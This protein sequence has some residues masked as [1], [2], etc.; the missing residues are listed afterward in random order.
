MFVLLFIA[1]TAQAIPS[2]S[3]HWTFTFRSGW[4]QACFEALSDLMRQGNY[5]VDEI[6]LRNLCDCSSGI[7]QERYSEQQVDAFGDNPPAD[8]IAWSKASIKM[9]LDPSD[10]I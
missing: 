6:K 8:F 7:I 3:Y 10:P 9:C 5:K 2:R 4:N 1:T